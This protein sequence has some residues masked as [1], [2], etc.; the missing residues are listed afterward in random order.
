MGQLA[1][2]EFFRTGCRKWN[3]CVPVFNKGMMPFICLPAI[4]WKGLTEE[5]GKQGRAWR[6]E[7]Q[8]KT[9]HQV[10]FCLIWRWLGISCYKGHF[11]LVAILIYW[12]IMGFLFPTV[13]SCS[14]HHSALFHC[15]YVCVLWM[16]CTVAAPQSRSRVKPCCTDLFSSCFSSYS[17]FCCFIMKVFRLIR[18]IC[19]LVTLQRGRIQI[20]L[21]CRDWIIGSDHGC[22]LNMREHWHTGYID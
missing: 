10:P 3:R 22:H 15:H 12:S 13:T 19:S 8:R 6:R 16:L 14:A 11:P 17:W 5:R 4:A 9:F 1:G 21:L 7:G 18:F 2:L 20:R